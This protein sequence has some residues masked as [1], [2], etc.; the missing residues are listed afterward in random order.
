MDKV[1]WIFLHPPR[2]GGNTIIETLLKKFPREEI[3]MAS[4]ARYK[5]DTEEFKPKKVRFMLGHAT[6]YGIHKLVPDKEPRYFI[7]LR[8]PAERL[9]SHYN[10]KMEKEMKKISFDAWYKNQIKNEMVHVLDLKLKGS[11]STRI[12][13]PSIFLPIIRK[14]NYKAF[15]FIQ[16]F[17]F[18]LLR[19][20]KKNDYRKLENAKKLLDLCWF[21]AILEKS[22]KDFKFLLKAM[23]IKNPKWVDDGVSK[24]IVKI[25]EKLRQKIYK[26]N[27]LDVQLYKYALKVREEKLKLIKKSK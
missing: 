4:L 26:E 5:L 11:P 10:A 17:I 2:T 21:V 25:D 3:F 9:I 13:T 24:K 22:D 20:N 19:L 1:L 6:Y 23:G 16:A 8:D 12:H 7:V 27:P 14:L 15:Y 18:N